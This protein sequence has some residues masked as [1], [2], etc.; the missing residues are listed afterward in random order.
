MIFFF[1][2][3]RKKKLRHF[4]SFLLL[5][6]TVI[7]AHK[8][9]LEGGKWKNPIPPIIHP[10]LGGIYTPS[11]EAKCGLLSQSQNKTLVILSLGCQ[12]G[13]FLLTQVALSKSGCVFEIKSLKYD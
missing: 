9:F 5:F 1:S 3:E 6:N 12:K 4:L 10:R 8:Y 7:L 2:K 11:S 13:T